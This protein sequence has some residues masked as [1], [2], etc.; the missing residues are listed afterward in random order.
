MASD[1]DYTSFLEKANQPTGAAT[2]STTS[3]AISKLPNQ[4]DLPSQSSSIPPA[5]KSLDVA[6]TSESDEPFEPFAVPYP[7][8]SL[9]DAAEFAKVIKHEKGKAGVEELSV[10]DFDPNG[11]YAGVL[12]KVAKAAGN[13]GEVRCFRVDAGRS[14][15]VLYYVVALDTEGGRLVGVRA[16][17]VES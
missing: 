11:E 7:I 4:A 8:S 1:E 5:L 13:K 12:E 17:S 3:S 9:P 2:A 10:K 16:M 6:F 14:T 15:K